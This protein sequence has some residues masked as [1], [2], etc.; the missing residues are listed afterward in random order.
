MLAVAASLTFFAEALPKDVQVW[1]CK[2]ADSPHVIWR[3]DIG[4]HAGTLTVAAGRVF[5]GSNNSL[6]IGVMNA[7]RAVMRCFD[8]ATGKPLWTAVHARLD[9]RNSDIQYSA[10]HSAAQ[11]AGNRV[12]YI[13]NRAEL[14][15]LDIDGFHDSQNDG[16]FIDESE[17]G[18][19]H[20]DIVWILDMR[21][22]L[23]VVPASAGDH[24]NPTSSVL[25]VG[26]TLYCVTGNGALHD[27]VA[28]RRKVVNPQAPSF[29]AVNRHTGK[30]IWQSA[31]PGTDIVWGQWSTPFPLPDRDEIVFPGG[32]GRLHGFD[33]KGT[34][35]WTVDAN[36]L[37][38]G[39]RIA[40]RDFKAFLFSPAGVRDGI[41]YVGT[42]RGMVP[43]A[44]D[45]NYP[46][47]AVDL[48]PRR[49]GP[50][51]LWK[52]VDKTVTG[53]AGA[54]AVDR[55]RLYVASDNGFL[56]ALDR[57]TGNQVQ[58][59]DLVDEAAPF[60]GPVIADGRLYLH[61]RM[62]D[63]HIFAVGPR[64]KYLGRFELGDAGEG[65]LAIVDGTLYVTTSDRLFALRL[66]PA[67]HP[68]P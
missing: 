44:W 27:P 28:D 15:C 13:S 32:D 59:I 64:L 40:D 66:P 25:V 24:A 52:F 7:N 43:F 8:A 63:V 68:S 48:H 34:R 38:G 39:F 67:P 58:C 21:K 22:D 14:M 3:A 49:D 31:V 50:T 45:R 54:L 41:V 30:V 20:A 65:G 17:T 5:V 11:V 56:I 6:A 16:P 60:C 23:G 9:D 37:P 55:D 53:T 2:P 4:T 42:G 61:S 19:S 62:G 10:L 33:R 26:D 46:V 51:V 18:K 35:R 12:Y 36:D 29:I 57:R 47:F 1:N